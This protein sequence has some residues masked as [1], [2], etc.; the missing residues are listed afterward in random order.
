MSCSSPLTIHRKGA[1]PIT[2][3]CGWCMNCRIVRRNRLSLL[4]R[5]QQYIYS[6]QN[7][8]SSFCT[9]TYAPEYVPINKFGDYTLRLN[10]LQKFFKRL[11]QYCKRHNLFLDSKGNADFSYIA[12]GEYGDELGRCHYHFCLFGI[13]SDFMRKFCRDN[14]KFG[15]IQS[16]PLVSAQIR[17]VAKYLDK[18]VHGSELSEQFLSKDK[19]PPFLVYSKGLARDFLTKNKSNVINNGGRFIPISKYWSDKLGLDRSI[20]KVSY[21][22][23]ISE[24]AKLANMSLP[25]YNA[26][27]AYFSELS[28]ISS[29]RSHGVAVDDSSLVTAR[30]NYEIERSRDTSSVQTIVDSL[31]K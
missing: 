10:D 13:D 6:L 1:T 17:Y 18:Q 2:V 29:L 26:Q 25:L 23:S 12:N 4:G 11:R 24:R 22:K 3:N 8:G 31:I 15:I 28:A 30:L 5:Y 20:D 27:Q 16:K 9:L 14:W 21:I 7:R 19:E